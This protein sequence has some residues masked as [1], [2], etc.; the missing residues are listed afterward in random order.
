MKFRISITSVLVYILQ[1]GIVCVLLITLRTYI[2]NYTLLHTS[3]NIT[4]HSQRIEHF[5]EPTFKLIE[6][7]RENILKLNS[8]FNV[9]TFVRRHKTVGLSDYKYFEHLDNYKDI[10][11]LKI[12]VSKVDAKLL[13][14]NKYYNITTSN[15][16]KAQITYANNGDQF[17]YSNSLIQSLYDPKP[18]SSYLFKP[19]VPDNYN[20]KD[21][22]IP[23]SFIHIIPNAV[24]QP[25]GE[26]LYQDIE[27]SPS[28]CENQGYPTLTHQTVEQVQ[29]YDEVFTISQ[30]WGEGFFHFLVE[31]I[32]RAIP[33]LGFLQKYSAIKIHMKTHNVFMYNLLEYLGINK[34]RLIEGY[35][36]A[37]I[38]YMPAG[39]RCGCASLFNIQLLSFYMKRTSPKAR[40]GLPEQ[41]SILL[42]K[43]SAKRYFEQHQNIL[44]SLQNLTSKY[45][46]SVE[47]YDD[48]HLPS[49]TDTIHLFSKANI[50]VAAHG[51]GL[52][53]LIFS[54]PGTLVVEGLC[55]SPQINMCYGRLIHVL[56]LIYYGI[57]PDKSCQ[58]ISAEDIIPT[59]KIYLDYLK[60]RQ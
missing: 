1:L 26:V 6:V 25:E 11:T 2:P 19:G 47:V 20:I 15:N 46:G 59:V 24:I 29:M 38:V 44:S 37:R 48:Q 30:F 43:R 57:I 50:V 27:I 28:G 4:I 23:L 3:N 32:P 7:I 51:S 12:V 56:G 39:T 8:T 34:S 13:L 22:S 45:D 35:V 60:N 21:G 40:M 52:S 31:D 49:L 5:M 33:F 18:V 58:Y 36:G 55:L 42:I 41:I 17:Y 53:N 10:N 9:T 54:K 14:V 16:T